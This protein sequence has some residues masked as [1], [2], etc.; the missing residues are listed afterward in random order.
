MTSL[1]VGVS[2]KEQLLEIVDKQIVSLPVMVRKVSSGSLV[3]I[4]PSRK[5]RNDGWSM[6]I[7]AKILGYITKNTETNQYDIPV[8]IVKHVPCY[9]LPSEIKEGNIG[10]SGYRY[11]YNT[12]KFEMD[13]TGDNV[14]NTQATEDLK[15]L[16]DEHSRL[17]RK[18][19]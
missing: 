6:C 14:V 12:S 13:L 18:Y 3:Y 8:R 5:L 9:Q 1:K 10:R 7:V 16:L 15:R 2:T 19:S 17:T 4:I 11:V